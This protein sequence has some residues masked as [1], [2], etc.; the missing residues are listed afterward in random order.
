MSIRVTCSGCHTR[1]NVSEKFA[2]KE[3]PCPKCKKVIQVPAA[4]E[5]VQVHAP[6][7]FGPKTTSGQA[8]F[9][10]ITRK[11]A[12]LSPVQ[13]VLIGA[14]I[15]GFLVVA[16]MARNGISDKQAFSSWVLLAAAVVVAVPCVFAGYT[17]LR[18]SELGAFEG[19]EL[20]TRIGACSLT[21][22]LSW[23]LIPLIGYAVGPEIGTFVGV[24]L[25][26]LAGAAMAYLLLSIDF[27]MGIL[28]YGLFLG[29]CILLR[30]LAGFPALPVIESNSS[31]IDDLLNAPEGPTVLLNP[32][33][34]LLQMLV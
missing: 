1:F 21:Y 14:T 17:F 20:W 2:G 33:Q 11:E 30:V 7:E 9:K 18:S 4:S 31:N 25:M 5:Q 16:F 13:L 23:C 22:P 15:V 12:S 24:G 8:V 19:Q 32:I 34:G 3:G 27:F 29:C 10:P 6:E 26:I 28:H